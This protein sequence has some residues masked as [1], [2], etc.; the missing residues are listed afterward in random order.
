MVTQWQ[1]IYYQHR[2]A[3]SIQQYPDFVAISAGMRVPAQR[4][5]APEELD[6]KLQW[7]LD[8]EGP[9]LLDVMLHPKTPLYPMVKQGKALDDMILGN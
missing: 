4:V 9:A 5:H 6:E 2:Y 1:D 7:L 3:H 8:A